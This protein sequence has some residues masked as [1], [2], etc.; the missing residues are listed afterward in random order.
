MVVEHTA[1]NHVETYILM[2][3]KVEK[4]NITNKENHINLQTVKDHLT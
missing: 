1:A 3:C 4:E 2:V